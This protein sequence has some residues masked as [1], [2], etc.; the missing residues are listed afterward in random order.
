MHNDLLCNDYWDHFDIIVE[1]IKGPNFHLHRALFPA[2][3]AAATA[4]VGIGLFISDSERTDGQA[5]Q[6]IMLVLLL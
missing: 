1:L 4:S 2:A 6:L 3:C 5:I